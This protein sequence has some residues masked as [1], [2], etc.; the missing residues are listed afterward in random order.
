M[1]CRDRKLNQDDAANQLLEAA[2]SCGLPQT[3]AM[4]TIQ[5]GIDS[6]LNTPAFVRKPVRLRPINHSP[7]PQNTECNGKEYRP[8]IIAQYAMRDGVDINELPRRILPPNMA[9]LVERYAALN[10]LPV[11]TIVP[12]VVAIM[13]ST[14]GLRRQV[15]IKSGM[16]S[17][18]NLFHILLGGTCAGKTTLLNYFLDPLQRKEY[19][20]HDKYK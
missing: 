11:E 15:W 4:A 20:L 19:E 14:L 3:E 13:G 8:G 9:A 10:G 18:P 16:Q 6:G 17:G 7:L 12:L 2:I 1:Y 5:S